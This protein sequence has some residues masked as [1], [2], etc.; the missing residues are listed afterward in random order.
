MD[1]YKMDKAVTALADQ[2]IKDTDQRDELTAKINN[3]RELAFRFEVQLI[4]SKALKTN[5][6][7]HPLPYS[8]RR[9]LLKMIDSVKVSES[10]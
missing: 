7:K 9:K 2:E 6:I 4:I 10:S 1:E 8:F 3:D 5:L